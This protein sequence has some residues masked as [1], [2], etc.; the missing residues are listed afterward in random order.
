MM[1]LR[2][3]K[4]K[5][6]SRATNIDKGYLCTSGAGSAYPSGSPDLLLLNLS[7]TLSAIEEEFEDTKEI[8]RIRKSKKTTQ[9]PK[10]QTTI[11]KTYTD[12]DTL[13]D[14]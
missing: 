14:V 13:E 1:S 8:I 5:C 9:G 10:G 2:R 3:R 11:Y 4:L 6:L 12:D 7:F